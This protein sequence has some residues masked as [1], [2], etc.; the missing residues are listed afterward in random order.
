V[1]P[2][3]IQVSSKEAYTCAWAAL[4][5]GLQMAWNPQYFYKNSNLEMLPD[6]ASID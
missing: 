5:R 3:V 6:A 4:D 1:Y 2:S